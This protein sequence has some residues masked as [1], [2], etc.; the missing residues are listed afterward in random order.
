MKL[1]VTN[2]ELSVILEA[3]GREKDYLNA[4]GNRESAH[5]VTDIQSKL[6][7]GE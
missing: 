1:E 5:K 6:K 7:N 2:T 4:Q 3:L